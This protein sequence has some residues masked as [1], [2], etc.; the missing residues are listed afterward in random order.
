IG[1]HLPKLGAALAM[2]PAAAERAILGE[3]GR[4]SVGVERVER[5]HVA[6]HERFDRGAVLYLADDGRVVG[7]GGA[8]NARQDDGDGN[9]ELLHDDS[10]L[11]NDS[12]SILTRGPGSV[13]G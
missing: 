13:D 5:A 2:L 9:D 10:P 8:R 7:A 6:P 1:D 11:K 4:V 3:D 12:T